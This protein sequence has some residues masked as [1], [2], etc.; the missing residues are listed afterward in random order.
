MPHFTDEKTEDQRA[1]VAFPKA[2]SPKAGPEPQSVE[3]KK[4]SRRHLR[5]CKA[6]GREVLSHAPVRR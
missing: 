5:S 4:H 6:V 2:Q 3:A 1:E